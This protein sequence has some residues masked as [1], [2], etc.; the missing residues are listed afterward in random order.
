MATNAKAKES[1]VTPMRKTRATKPA[2]DPNS[3]EKQLVSLAVDLAEKQ[4]ID[5][6][7]SSSVINHFLKLA[8]SREEIERDILEKQAKLIGA[9]ADAINSDKDSDTLARQAIEA[10]SGYASSEK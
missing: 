6:T 5:G 10:L 7:A 2:H 8:S 4:L 3:R 9:K 1:K